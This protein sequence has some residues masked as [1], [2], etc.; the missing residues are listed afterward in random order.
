M[1]S[2]RQVMNSMIS[3]VIFI[4]LNR[5][6]KINSTILSLVLKLYCILWSKNKNR[7]RLKKMD[8]F[9]YNLNVI[10]H[11]YSYLKYG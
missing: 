3:T 6:I 2:G 8:I 5:V 7:K 11:T 1:L 9:T 10:N 4:L